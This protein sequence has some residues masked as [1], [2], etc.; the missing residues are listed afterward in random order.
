VFVLAR[1]AVQN[2]FQYGKCPLKKP[3][4]GGI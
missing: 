4:F 3:T 2:F 1:S